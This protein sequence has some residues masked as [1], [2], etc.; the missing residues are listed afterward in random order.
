MAE[1]KYQ[2]SSNPMFV[3]VVDGREYSFSVAYLPKD[4]YDWFCDVVGK[5]MTTIASAAEIKGERTVRSAIKE[6]LGILND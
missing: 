4:R 5:Q 3:H 6:A 1:I 2:D